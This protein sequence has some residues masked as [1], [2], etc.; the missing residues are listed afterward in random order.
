M[1]GGVIA[2]FMVAEAGADP[3]IEDVLGLKR[4]DQ[5]PVLD[6]NAPLI[7]T[8]TVDPEHI[9]KLARQYL[10]VRGAVA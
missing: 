6:A 2:Y 8:Q 5:V 7:D 4:C 9:Q 3:I 1:E 10:Q